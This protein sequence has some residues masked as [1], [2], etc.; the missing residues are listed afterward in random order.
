MTPTFKAGDD[1]SRSRGARSC[2]SATRNRGGL[3]RRQP[4]P[5]ATYRLQLTPASASTPP[6]RRRPPRRARRLPPLLLA[7]AE[8]VPGSTHGYDVVDPARLS[9][10]ARRRGG[11]R[12]PGRGAAA[13]TASGSSSTSCRTTSPPTPQ[14]VVVG[15]ARDSAVAAA[16]ADALRR[17]LGPAEAQA[18]GD[19]AAARPRRPLRPGARGRRHRASSGATARVILARDRYYEHALPGVAPFDSRRARRRGAPRLATTCSASRRRGDLAAGQDE[20]STSTRATPTCTV[21]EPHRPRHRRAEPGRSA[22]ALDAELAAVA[23]DVD[24]LD[25]LLDRQQLPPGPLAHRRR[26][27][28]LPAVLRHHAPLATLR[29]EDRPVFDATHALPLGWFADGAVDGLRVDHPDGLRDPAGYTQRLAAAAPD[30]LDRRGEDPATR[31]RPCPTTWPVDGTTGYEVADARSTGCSPIPGR[32]A[33]DRR[34]WRP[35][36]ATDGLRRCRREGKR[37]SS[38]EPLAADVRR[39]TDAFVA[40]LRGTSAPRPHARRRC[41]PRSSRWRWSCRCTGATC[42]WSRR[43]PPPTAGP[44]RSFLHRRAGARDRRRSTPSCSSSSG[45]SSR[46]VRGHRSR[47]RSPCASS[48]S[49]GRRRPRARRTRR[50]TAAPARPTDARSAPTRPASAST[51]TSCTRPRPP[52]SAGWP[53]SRRASTHDTKRSA[54]V[55]ARLPA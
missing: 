47:P 2:S 28:R 14:P 20:T 18:A 13:P 4:G 46:A 7:V 27:A 16:W 8:A 22:G 9:E 17:R 38:W 41:A 6:P 53:R 24:R 23:G 25:A 50:S 51:S 3:T 15:R 42:A 52:P 40:G 48:S 5:V 37:G 12:P 26:R 55:R 1:A 34:L 32:A 49:P 10:R 19:G 30:A 31:A 54:D 21:A 33:A 29:T 43:P 35:T 39:L 11:L 36:P 44:R 45:R